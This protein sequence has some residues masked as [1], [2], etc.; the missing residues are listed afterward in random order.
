MSRWGF[1]IICVLSVGVA[2][3]AI[4]VYGGKPLGSVVHPEMRQVFEAQKVGIYTHVFASTIALLT[5]PWQFLAVVRSRW[6]SLH[7]TLGR[8]YL[9]VGVGVGGVSGLYMSG[10]AFGGVASTM[11]F[12]L[13]AVVWLYTGILGFQSARRRLWVVHQRWMMRNYGLTFAAVTLRGYLGLGFAFNIP[14][15]VFYPVL[16]WLA[17]VPNLI[18]ADYV[19]RRITSKAPISQEH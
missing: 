6:P 7:K 1:I 18:V 15:E 16:A 3:Y 9:L 12:G 2:G 8:V 5:G 19:A 4:A 11:G 10:F 17:W 14:F 13:L